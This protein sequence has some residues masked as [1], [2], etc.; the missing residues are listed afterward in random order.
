MEFNELIKIGR[1]A[2]SELSG[3]FSLFDE[4]A[5]ENTLR[6]MNAFHAGRLSD[7]HF[8]GTTGYGYNDSGRDTLDAVYADVF[9]AEDALVRIGF[10]GGT[11]AIGCALRAAAPA[12]GYISLVGRPYDTLQ[13]VLPYIHAEPRPDGRPDEE[14]IL[15]L[16]RP[17]TP[18]VLIQRS[19]GYSTRATLSIEDVARLISLV[20]GVSPDIA[21]VVDNCYCEFVERLEPC[22][23]GADLTA[24]SLIKNP[25]GGLALTGGYIAGK[26]CFVNKAAEALTVPGIGRECGPS[27]GQNRSLFQGLFMAPH[28]VAQ[29]LK[30]AVFAAKMLEK[31]GYAVSPSSDEPRYDIIQ[32][33]LFGDREKLLRFA[34]GIQKGSPVDSF[35]VPEPWAMP[36]YGDEV[37]MA[38][39]T[40]V[41]GASIEL[42]CDGPLR[43][44]YCAY[45]QGGLTYEAG[46]LGVLTALAELLS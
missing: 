20:R 5:F 33:L 14:A 19:R 3:R 45:L 38:A 40:F 42:S 43:E 22:H 39:G 36:G 23:V 30:T 16:L 32:S 41:Q 34:R 28:T 31:L 11:H 9:G 21:V 26:S 27:L 15:E 35:A 18:A 12:G 17:D 4:T 13:G 24:G 46:K 7:S 1:E 2:E 44:P 10:V 37:V 25:G 8:A 29:A 6:V